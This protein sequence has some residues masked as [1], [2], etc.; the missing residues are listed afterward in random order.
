MIE[1]MKNIFNIKSTLSVLV[2]T[3]GLLAAC[4]DDSIIVYD[5]IKQGTLGFY[6]HMIDAPPASIKVSQAT[7][8]TYTFTPEIVGATTDEI[9]SFEISAELTEADGTN[10]KPSKSVA[11]IS[12]FPVDGTSKRP[13]GTIVVTAAQLN[14]AVGLTAANYTAGRIVYFHT[15][16]VMKTRGFVDESNVN[17]NLSGPAYKAPFFHQVTIKP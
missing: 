2:L 11:S 7:T 10:V 9:T 8:A 4:R 15:K 6:A 3:M 1:N 13:R 5:P 16:L 14:S 12:T 17:P